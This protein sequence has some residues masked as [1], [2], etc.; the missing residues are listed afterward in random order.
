M[1]DRTKWLKNLGR[2]GNVT[3]AEGLVRVEDYIKD[4][5]P[6]EEVAVMEKAAYYR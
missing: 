2:D 1:N 4:G 6:P 5:R 3:P